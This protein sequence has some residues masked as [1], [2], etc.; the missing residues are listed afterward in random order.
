VTLSEEARARLEAMAEVAGLTL[1]GVVEALALHPKAHAVVAA[2]VEAFVDAPLRA[3]R[4]ELRAVV[5]A[6]KKVR[7]A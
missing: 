4:A 7:G 3:P 2:V 1:S 6:K 5:E